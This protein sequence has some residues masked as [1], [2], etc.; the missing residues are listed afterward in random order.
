M[1][2]RTPELETKWQERFRISGV[3]F[4][5][6]AKRNPQRGLATSN[7]SGVMQLY[8][9]DLKTGSMRQL[10]DVPTGKMMGYISPDGEY[11]YYLKDEGSNEIGHFVRV[12]FEGGAEVDITPSLSPYASNSLVIS[13]DAP[14]LVLMAADQEG[15]KLYTLELTPDGRVDDPRLLYL[16]RSLLQSVVISNDG[17]IAVVNSTELSGRLFLNLLAVDTRSGAK[18]A[19]LW[20]GGETS[21][22]AVSFSPLSGDSRLL[23]TSNRSGFDRPLLWNPLTGERTDLLLEELEGDVSPLDWS[24]NG[25]YLLLQHVNQAVQQLYVY[26]LQEAKLRKLNHPAG[27]YLSFAGSGTY[28]LSNDEIFASWQDATHPSQ[29]IGLDVHSGEQTRVVIPG[30]AVPA[31]H[32]WRSVSFPSSDETIIQAWLALPEGQE[33]FPTILH[34]H[35]GPTSVMME[36]FSAQAQAWLDHG[37]AYLSV[38]YRGSTTFGKDFQNQIVGNLGYWEVEDVKAAVEWLVKNGTAD[39]AKILKT[40]GSYGGY[41]TLMSLGK[42]PVYFAGGMAGV[43]IADWE[44]MYEDQAR[45][46]RG[47]Q[48]ALFGGPPETHAEQYRIS[49]PITYAEQVKAPILILQGR[50]DTR[51]PSRQM[52]VYLDKM[53]GLDKDVRIHWF[54]AGHGSLQIKEQINQMKMMLDF[55]YE[56]LGEG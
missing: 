11:V 36:S 26:D 15:F 33:P 13:R 4:T 23:A 10:T 20:D 40:G 51:C 43:A 50:N 28:F 9:W 32:G 22:H 29:V 45:T 30:A 25:R 14:R 41:M 1:K 21:L 46:L 31:G 8:A 44:L 3:S 48:E 24:P 2:T 39:P 17:N 42:L 12:P 49:S 56:V 6:I 18:I 19:E 47:Y 27:S 54:D 53:K 34:T 37:F 55:A 52:E 38:N 35:G 16:S 7:Q 5:Q